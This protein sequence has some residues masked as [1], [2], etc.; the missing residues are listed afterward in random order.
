MEETELLHLDDYKLTAYGSNGILIYCASC[1]LEMEE[2][3]N[4]YY[5]PVKY[6]SDK[7]GRY[8]QSCRDM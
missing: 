4:G 3:V 1:G 7:Y 6:E 8:C 5:E 2:T